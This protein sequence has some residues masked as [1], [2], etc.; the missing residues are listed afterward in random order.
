MTDP[1][2]HELRRH[3]WRLDGRP[4]RTIED[5]RE[6][7]E[8]V[9]FCLMYPISAQDPGMRGGPEIVLPMFIGAWTGGDDNLPTRQHAFADPRAHEATELAVR[10]LRERSAYEASV[11]GENNLLVAASV[12]PYFYALAGDRNPRQEPRADRSL[13]PLAQDVLGGI[14]RAGPVT[15]RRLAETLGGD[16]SEAAIDRALSELAARLRIARVDYNPRDG[17]SWD[18]LYRWSPEAVNEGMHLAVAAA[19]SALLSKYLDCVIAADEKEIGDCFSP[20]IARSKVKEALNALLA[21]RELE[22]VHVGNRTLVQLAPART[23]E[24]PRTS[25][26]RA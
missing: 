23:T 7:L 3:R 11:F 13:S 16:L 8:S 21:A 20:L 18:V 24:R 26:R 2:L 10:L 12:F 25:R 14:Q 19:L 9:G 17:S 15:K 22:F 6:F 5:A 4:V 1:E